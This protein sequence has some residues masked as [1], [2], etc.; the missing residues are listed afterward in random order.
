[1]EI[2]RNHSTYLFLWLLISGISFLFTALLGAMLYLVINSDTGNV[3]FPL[4]F[5][6]TALFIFMMSY[7]IERGKVNFK[8]AHTNGFGKAITYCGLSILLFLIGQIQSWMTIFGADAFIQTNNAY[9][10]LFLLSGL[11][12]LHVLASIPFFLQLYFRYN[13]YSGAEHDIQIFFSDPSK[14]RYLDQL[15]IYLHFMGILWIV[16]LLAFGFLSII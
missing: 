2:S 6:I 4:W 14:Y 13:K 8:L 15:A 5:L 16:L 10:F 12:L 9:A 7:F 1:M 11:H 3:N